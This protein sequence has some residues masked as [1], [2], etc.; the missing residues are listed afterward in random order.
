MWEAVEQIALREEDRSPGL[1]DDERQPIS[2][3]A[4][5]EWH[6]GGSRFEDREQTDDHRERALD[7]DGDNP[8]R[9]GSYR[10]EPGRERVGL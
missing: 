2:W 8:R 5:I 6:V 7:G 1:A 4:R 3:V 10:S 9:A